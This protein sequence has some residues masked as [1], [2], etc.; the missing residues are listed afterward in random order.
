MCPSAPGL[1][2]A[3]TAWRLSIRG[4]GDVGRRRPEA[5]TGRTPRRHPRR[6]GR[7]APPA[8]RDL[9]WP[10]ASRRRLR[11]VGRGEGDDPGVRPLRLAGRVELGGAGLGGDRDA[12]VEPRQ[13]LAVPSVAT[14]CISAF[15]VAAVSGLIGRSHTSR[16]RCASACGPGCRSVASTTNGFIITPPLATVCGDHRHVQRHHLVLLLAEAA[17]RQERQVLVEVVGAAERAG[18]RRGAGR[19]GAAGRCPT[20]ACRR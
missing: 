17:H 13:Q 8:R 16:R 11:V 14:L 5:A 4:L 19:S 12:A 1:G 7:Q 10:R 2:G 18:R 3:Q 9:G 15:S 6:S 20:P